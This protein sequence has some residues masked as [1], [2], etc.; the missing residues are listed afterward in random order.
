MHYKCCNALYV[1]L[2]CLF[3]V[4]PSHCFFFM[5]ILCIIHYINA[6]FNV[7][8]CWYV[9]SWAGSRTSSANAIKL[10]PPA[11]M[12]TPDSTSYVAC[13]PLSA[14]ACK[15]A[16]NAITWIHPCVVSSPRTRSMKG[17]EAANCMLHRRT[18][19]TIVLCSTRIVFPCGGIHLH[20][21]RVFLL[22][23]VLVML[24]IEYPLCE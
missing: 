20:D 5:R 17:E 2:L 19:G 18:G 13:L 8:F 10:Q 3:N 11:R 15:T 4:F 9:V 16:K 1:A 23:N 22:F 14:P 7:L 6:Y 24:A 21:T 12:P